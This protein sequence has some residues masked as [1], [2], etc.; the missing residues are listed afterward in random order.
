MKPSKPRYAFSKMNALRDLVLRMVVGS[1][2]KVDE[3]KLDVK[4]D[5][6]ENL[7]NKE[8][9]EVIEKAKGDQDKAQVSKTKETEDVCLSKCE[10]K[11]F[12]IP[13]NE[14]EDENE[15]TLVIPKVNSAKDSA[16]LGIFFPDE[17]GSVV[18]E[19]LN[20]SKDPTTGWRSQSYLRARDAEFCIFRGLWQSIS[21]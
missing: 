19:R 21:N 17:C 9:H 13:N 16:I 2:L 3:N 14:F 7:A 15:E 4:P 10:G 18:E 20:P 12:E 11:L 5:V 6:D 8:D 1:D